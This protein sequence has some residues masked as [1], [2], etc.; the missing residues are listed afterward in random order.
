[1]TPS[2]PQRFRDRIDQSR[3]RD[4]GLFAGVGH[5][6]EVPRPQES[7]RED[8]HRAKHDDDALQ[9]RVVANLVARYDEQNKNKVSQPS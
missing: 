7:L 2:F 4:G 9:R 1:V 6:G 3:G 8:D 5:L